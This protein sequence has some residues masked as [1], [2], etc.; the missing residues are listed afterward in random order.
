MVSVSRD[1]GE[2]GRSCTAEEEIV[3][4][5]DSVSIADE[6]HVWDEE[7]SEEE[8]CECEES[9]ND[10]NDSENFNIFSGHPCWR[11]HAFFAMLKNHFKHLNFVPSNT[12]EVRDGIN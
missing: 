4:V 8:E 9:E 5:I 1:C 11:T 3:S 12:R 10:G 2:I 7:A 6:A